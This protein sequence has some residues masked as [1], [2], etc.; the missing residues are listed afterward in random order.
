MLVSV[1]LYV[2]FILLLIIIDVL[3]IIYN[4]TRIEF[5]Y[6]EAISALLYLCL[7][8]FLLIEGLYFVVNWLLIISAILS[9]LAFFLFKKK[10]KDSQ[11]TIS[12]K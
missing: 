12:L 1:G 11:K 8:I 3:L 10:N 4:S 9:L 6:F 5:V 7:A 2:I